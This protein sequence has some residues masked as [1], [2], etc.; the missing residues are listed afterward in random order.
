MAPAC[1]RPTGSESFGFR[2]VEDRLS[3]AERPVGLRVRPR[4]RDLPA[5]RAGGQPH[6]RDRATSAGSVA[7]LSPGGPRRSGWRSRCR[8]PSSP[9][10]VALFTPIVSNLFAGNAGLVVCLVISLFTYGFEFFAVCLGHGRFG[11]YGVSMAAEHNSNPITRLCHPRES[12]GPG[13]DARRSLW[14]PACAGIT[15]RCALIPL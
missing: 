2:A 11:A 8:S 7:V 12:G 10:R 4:P 9:S 14:I 6:D 13:A 15:I 1:A 3:G 5:A